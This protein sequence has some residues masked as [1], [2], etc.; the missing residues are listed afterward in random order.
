MVLDECRMVQ[1]SGERYRMVKVGEGWCRVVQDG[2]RWY[3][4]AQDGAGWCRMDAEWY[5]V[6]QDGCRAV[7]G[8]AG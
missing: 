5:R 2:A 1:D 4:V 8:G 7:Q 6:V 3:R